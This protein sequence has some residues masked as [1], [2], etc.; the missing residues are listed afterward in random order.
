[1]TESK[2]DVEREC[3]RNGYQYR[4][5]EDGS[6]YYEFVRPS[7]VRHPEHGDICLFNNFVNG[8]NWYKGWHPFDTMEGVK[9][10]FWN[11]WGNG[12]EFDEEEMRVMTRLYEEF[13]MGDTWKS[14]DLLLLDNHY[15]THGRMPFNPDEGRRNIGVMMGNEVVRTSFDPN[16]IGKCE[17]AKTE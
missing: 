6:L 13:M 5:N 12:E 16:G 7:F 17:F 11:Q 2:E 9:R 4:W 8:V 14:G 3:E 15:S 1:M 10:P